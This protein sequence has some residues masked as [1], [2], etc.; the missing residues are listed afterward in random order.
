MQHGRSNAT[1]TDEHVLSVRV[2]GGPSV[3][4]E[5]CPHKKKKKKEKKKVQEVWKGDKEFCVC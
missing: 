3:N 2:G 1:A 4:H 5:K